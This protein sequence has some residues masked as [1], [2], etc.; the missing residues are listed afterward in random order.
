MFKAIICDL[1]RCLFNPHSVPLPQGSFLKIFRLMEKEVDSK[2]KEKI[3]K[4][5]YKWGLPGILKRHQIPEQ[6]QQKIKAIYQV[7]TVSPQAK[8]YPDI[9]ILKK[10]PQL[11]ILVTT[12]L[13][14]FQNSKIKTMHLEEYFDECI[15]NKTDNTSNLWTKKRIFKKNLKKHQLNPAE[16]LVIG[17]SPYDELIP[18]KELGMK[19]A[20]SLRDNV[21]KV[22][23][24]D[25]YI[26]SFDELKEILK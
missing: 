13:E 17:D 9:V 21:K 11:K 10:L 24:F 2:K 3:K 22:E 16:V 1:D 12:G 25:Y 14:K 7:P 6:L 19:T 4:E 26:K 8:P 23:G 15:I 5:I 18:A 20:Q